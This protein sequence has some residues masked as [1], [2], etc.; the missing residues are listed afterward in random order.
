MAGETELSVESNPHLKIP[1]IGTVIIEDDVEIG[2]NS[3]IDRATIGAT[4][5]GKGTKIDN[6]VMVAHN[7]RVG[8]EVLLVSQ[9]GIAGSCVVEDRA[10]LAGQVGVKDHMITCY[11][12]S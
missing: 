8:K 12:C 9:V 1:Q 7:C 2:A 4:I 10:I 6:Q 11:S 5:I 3:T